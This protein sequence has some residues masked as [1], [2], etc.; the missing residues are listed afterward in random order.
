MTH[1][2]TET[3]TLFHYKELPLQ[4]TF[5]QAA[6]SNYH[7]TILY[8]HGGGLMFGQRNDLPTEYIQLLTEAGY[9]VLALDYLLAPESKLDV[10]LDNILRAVDWFLAEGAETLN[11]PTSD[12]YVMGRS[13]GGYLALYTSV[14]ATQLPMGVISFY[15]YFNLNE[16]AFNMPSRHFLKYQKVPEQMLRSLVQYRPLVAAPME[17]RFPLYLSARQRGNWISLLTAKPSEAASFSLSQ[18]Q[19][20]TLPRTFI[21]AATGDP[22][23]PVR[24][25][26]LLA[27]YIPDAELILLELNEHDFDRTAIQQHGLPVYRRLVEWL[28]ADTVKN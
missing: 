14:H 10:I 2:Q 17:E 15:G 27:N 12:Y 13:A 24:Q 22:D 26:K 19:L 8:L 20:A 16:A 5:Y 1:I 11:V 3:F 21:T 7:A 6:S 4:A 18:S 28:A 25:S 23:V 9:G